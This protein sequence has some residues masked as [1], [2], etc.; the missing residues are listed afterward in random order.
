MIESV[1]FRDSQPQ[2]TER[3]AELFVTAIRG[4]YPDLADGP[5]LAGLHDVEGTYVVYGGAF[6]V[7]LHRNE[8]I[9]MGGIKRLSDTKGEMIR[10]AVAPE[11]QERGIG[12]ALL[13]AIEGRAIEMGITEIILDTT[14]EQTSALHL[15]T[16]NGY[17]IVDR[18]M[19]QHPT[20]KTFDTIYFR[21]SLG[22][23]AA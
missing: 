1:Y 10:V 18:Q 23:S 22:R 21:K 3:L 20:G 17:E 14:A 19:I 16:N 5:W 11:M 7:G 15:Y 4:V 9:A 8:I 6:I 13:L 12:H 2:D